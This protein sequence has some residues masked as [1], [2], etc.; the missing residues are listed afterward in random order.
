[1]R[2]TTCRL[3]PEERMRE[4]ARK[5]PPETIP[6]VGGQGR[7]MHSL[8]DAIRSGGTACSDFVEYACTLAEI[9]TLGTMAKRV[10]TSIEWDA[11]RMR[12][13]NSPEAEKLLR[14]HVREGWEYRA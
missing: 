11:E 2:P 13:P 8:F 5:L 10:A 9:T 7:H 4:F 12:V 1:M 3:I 6:R 14:S